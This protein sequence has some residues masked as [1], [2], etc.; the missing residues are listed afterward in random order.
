MDHQSHA[1]ILTIRGFL[2]TC[3]K[4]R[5]GLM[6]DV[7]ACQMFQAEQN[8]DHIGGKYQSCLRWRWKREN[9]KERNADRDALNIQPLRPFPKWIPITE[10]VH[11]YG[12]LLIGDTC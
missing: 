5:E 4:K 6:Q 7:G 2:E 1:D 8:G 10:E 9:G 11:E 12:R 3:W